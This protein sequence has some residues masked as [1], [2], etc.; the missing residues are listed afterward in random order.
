M[1]S[2]KRVYF[3]GA[4]Q[5]D[6]SA[7]DRSLLGGKG[8]NLGEMTRLGLPVPPGFTVTTEVCNE[9]YSLGEKMPPG[10]QD[11][12]LAALDRVEK[13]MDARFGD[14]SNPL[15]VSV[16]S[17]AAISMPGMMDTILNLGLNDEAVKGLAQRADPRFA[18]DSYRR[19]IAMYAHIVL[20]TKD[21]NTDVDPFDEALAAQKRVRGVENDFELTAEALMELVEEYKAIVQRV[22]RQ[23]FP[24]DPKTQ[25][26]GATA[27]VFR[28]WF[29]DRAV[30]YRRING[31]PNDLGTAVTVQSMVFGNMGEDCG[32]GVA[33]TRDPNDG[34]KRF[35]GEYL[36]NAQGEDVVAGIRTPLPINDSGQGT[37]PSTT[38]EQKMPGVY[39]ELDDVRRKLEIHYRDMQDIEFTIQRNKLFLLQT[40]N[41]K[42]TAAAAVR[43]AVDL[44]HEGLIEKREAIMRVTPAHVDQLLHPM[45]DPKATRQVIAKG[46]PASPGAATGKVVFSAEEAADRGARGESII[47]LRVETSPEDVA[48]MH[49]S[50]GV[51]TAR[52]GM[53]SHAAVV[54]RGMGKPCVV[55]CSELT[56]SYEL[57]Q[58]QSRGH[59][60]R[61]DDLITIDG[62]SGEVMVGEVA[63][64]QAGGSAQ[65]DEL[66]GWVDEFRRLKVRTNADTPNDAATA[67]GF[68]AEGIGLCRTEHMF[69]DSARITAMR[70][71][72]MAESE[73]GRRAALSKLAPM[74]RADFEGIFRAMDGL[75]VTIRLLDPP[76]HEFLPQGDS[77]MEALAAVL[78]RDPATLKLKAS[79]LHEFNPML[80]LR[81]CRLGLKHPEIYEMQTR[82]I[83]EAAVVVEQ[84]GVHVLP[85]IMV[86]LIA[87]REE[88]DQIRKLINATAEQV[89]EEHRRRVE[90]QVGTMIEIPRA[91]LTA[92]EIAEDADFFSFGTNDL[93]QM[94]FGISRDD[95][96]G[97]LPDYVERG[98]LANEPFQVL[99]V[100]GVG[101]LVKWA[102]ERG[103]SVKPKLKIGICGEH[104][105]EPNSVAFCH[106]VG[107]D[108]VSCSPFRVPVARLAA[109]QASLRDQ[110]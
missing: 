55:G 54:A 25:L 110:E 85:E 107:L 18:Y 17:G 45:L 6:G 21:G 29:N 60:I 91:A 23:P 80:G 61:P 11:D 40:R 24:Q 9:F 84:S 7:N 90:Y 33:F 16:R 56:V 27:A 73:T 32:T 26:F 72:I 104:G 48:G 46:L 103:R 71:M 15:L 49:Q 101:Q 36:L 52:G 12:M 97:F 53:T 63:T 44:V 42:R 74:Q 47:L 2:N 82:A 102:S 41:G 93:T 106:Q 8:A 28:S 20:G 68:G 89:F 81:G 13:L 88:L 65:F 31:I 109:A 96:A 92:D 87:T 39:R 62:G 77:E 95:S 64:V 100:K 108:Y 3:F 22:A 30:A 5:A 19:L 98:I 35:F 83:L 86:P 76:L 105:G 34:T 58:A 51:L 59:V 4:G 70:E 37:D 94:T 67:R 66:M 43:I 57:Q 75:P 99:D 1:S 79:Q 69:F 10:L 50:A 14:A 38:L 78:S